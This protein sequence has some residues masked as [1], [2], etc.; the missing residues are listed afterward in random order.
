VADLVVRGDYVAW[1]PGSMVRLL[2][3][4]LAS[5][6]MVSPGMICG[7]ATHGR[8]DDL[9]SG[10]AEGGSWSIA[11]VGLTAGFPIGLGGSFLFFNLIFK[12]EH[13]HH[14]YCL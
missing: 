10:F 5:S 13:L 11:N 8:T 7:W 14:L 2:V 1:H 6:L 12:D 4:A 3:H 9:L